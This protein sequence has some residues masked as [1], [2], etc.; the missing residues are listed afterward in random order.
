MPK[1]II[2][3][4][5]GITYMNSTLLW[6]ELLIQLNECQKEDMLASS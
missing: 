6:L 1:S 3:P 4:D 5:N 2:V